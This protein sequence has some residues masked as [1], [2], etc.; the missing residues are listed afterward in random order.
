MAGSFAQISAA[1]IIA[2][3]PEI[4]RA[5]LVPLCE[6][7]ACRTSSPYMSI[8]PS[9]KFSRAAIV[10]L[11]PLRNAEQRTKPSLG[12]GVERMTKDLFVWI[13]YSSLIIYDL[14]MFFKGMACAFVGFLNGM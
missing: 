12:L 4:R 10:F 13:Q 8:L 6:R 2:H 5:P 7:P 14:E 9:L 11:A 3:C 1:L